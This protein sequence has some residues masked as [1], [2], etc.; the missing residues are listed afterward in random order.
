MVWFVPM[1]YLF[2][3]LFICSF[4]YAANPDARQRMINI[5][6]LVYGLPKCNKDLLVAVIKFL[7]LVA[8]HEDINKMTSL[9]LA[10]V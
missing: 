4:I 1:T 8:E 7:N 5:R 6:K 2:V 3:Y 10:V 9:N